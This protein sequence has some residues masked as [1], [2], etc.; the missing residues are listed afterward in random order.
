MAEE[1]KKI[2]EPSQ[3]PAFL[4]EYLPEN[5]YTYEMLEKLGFQRKTSHFSGNGPNTDLY[6]YYIHL[7]GLTRDE[8]PIQ[9]RDSEETQ[10]NYG[11][12]SYVKK[13]NAQH[14]VWYPR[15]ARP[16]IETNHK[17]HLYIQKEGLSSCNDCD[18]E[19]KSKRLAAI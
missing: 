11:L 7:W 19:P 17:N 18:G 12:S 3:I 8:F 10:P 16:L 14:E 9:K 2:T 6:G 13:I 4:D 1:I 15:A 5:R